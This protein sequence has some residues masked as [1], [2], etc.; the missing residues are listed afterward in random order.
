VA[1]LERLPTLE[2]T[3]RYN[4]ACGHAQL[5]GIAALPRSGMTAAEGQAE[6]ERAIEWLHRAAD[7][8]Y[9]NVALMRRDADLEPLRSRPDFQLLMMDLSSRRSRSRRTPEGST[10]AGSKCRGFDNH[11]HEQSDRRDSQPRCE[12][13]SEARDGSHVSRA[14]D[15][16]PK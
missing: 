9:R 2:P 15:S 6:A 3:D 11:R 13:Q 1:I 12:H 10:P 16:T 4:L 5:A 7:A 8:G 14:V